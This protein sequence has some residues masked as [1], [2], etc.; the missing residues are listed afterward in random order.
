MQ[1][2]G[3][4]QTLDFVQPAISNNHFVQVY[5]GD[6]MVCRQIFCD[7]GEDFSVA[8]TDSEQLSNVMVADITKVW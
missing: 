8:D 5:N 4:K 6:A 3:N 7:F 2:C 1:L